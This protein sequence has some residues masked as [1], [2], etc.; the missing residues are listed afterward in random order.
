MI[1]AF[2]QFSLGAHG[3]VGM[4]CLVALAQ[5]FL[6][7]QNIEQTLRELGFARD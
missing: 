5:Y 4:I 2:I 3:F 7:N 1:E 6:S